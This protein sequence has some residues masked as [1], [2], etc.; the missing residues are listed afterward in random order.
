[1]RC[2]TYSRQRRKCVDNDEE[3]GKILHELRCGEMT[4]TGEVA[5]GRNYGSVDATPLF[6]ILLSEYF[7][8]T[9]DRE[10]LEEMRPS[11][12]SRAQLA[13]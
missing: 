9:G 11:L 6:I 1:M 13:N 8:W 10:L 2:T 5:F 12:V 7:Q 3:P 4:A